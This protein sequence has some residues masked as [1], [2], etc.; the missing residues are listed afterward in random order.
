M[1]MYDVL[2]LGGGPAGLSAALALGRVRRSVLICDN[3]RPRN[4]AS[5]HANNL[6]SQDGINPS[7]WRKKARLDLKKYETVSFLDGT[8]TSVEKLE[9]Y[10]QGTFLSGERH[11]FRKII[12][13][14]GVLD[15][16]PT[17]PGFEELWGK[18]VFHCPYC[19]GYEVADMRLGMVDSGGFAEHLLPMLSALSKDIVVF[20][21]GIS[22]ISPGF[23][24]FLEKKNIQIFEEKIER[25]LYQGEILQ[26]VVLKNGTNLERDA[27]FL[28]PQ[29]PIRMK[30]NVGEILGCKTTEM[31][32]F[33]IDDFGRTTVPGVFAAGDIVTFKQSV[34]G[35]VAL[36]QAAGAG[37]AGDLLSEDFNS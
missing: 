18:S 20:T 29:F 2:V 19:H 36:G 12:L 22:S 34:A 5:S 1:G 4:A 10:F 23:K 21:N 3:E 32:F 26:S 37:A 33:Q 13:A 28:A 6:I 16:L 9:T 17:V 35:A 27:L 25:L 14:H 15:V 11:T 8:L 31:G 24:G 30:S 7:E